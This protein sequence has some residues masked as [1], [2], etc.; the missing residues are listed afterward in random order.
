MQ[1]GRRVRVVAGSGLPATDPNSGLFSATLALN[2]GLNG[3]IA[4]PEAI[5][6]G[7]HAQAIIEG[8]QISSFDLNDW[9]LWLWAN[10]NFQVNGAAANHQGDGEA[11][12][13]RWAFTVASGDGKQ[14]GWAGLGYY[15]IDGLGV[16][17]E[18]LDAQ[19]VTPP[20]PGQLDQTWRA[21]SNG[22]AGAYLNVTLVN[23]S[24]GAKTANQWF[25]VAFILQPELGW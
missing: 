19:T 12:R 8:I 22:Q 24:A 7:R 23:R 5:A 6:A 21:A 4:L 2:V 16:H 25:Q 9:E 18:D 14:I 17:Y 11:F 10:S 13:G 3:R 15:Y 1:T 20:P